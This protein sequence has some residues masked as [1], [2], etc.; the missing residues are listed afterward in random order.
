M[1]SASDVFV[2]PTFTDGDSI[3]VREALSLGIPVIASDCVER[4][5][6]VV[7]FKTG[8]A[9]DLSGKLQCALVES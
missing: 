8:N 9:G 4:P 7:L 5:D 2:R 1:I 3:S 6:G